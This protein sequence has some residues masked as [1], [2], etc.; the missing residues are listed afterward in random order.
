[1]RPALAA[2]KHAQALDVLGLNQFANHTDIRAAW[3]KQAFETHPDRPGGSVDAFRRVN[4]AYEI[5]S[6][7][8][9]AKAWTPP[10]ETYGAPDPQPTV[11]PDRPARPRIKTSIV[12]LSQSVAELCR[13]ELENASASN[14]AAQHVPVSM[15]RKGREVSYVVASTLRE[16][17]NRVALPT[18]ELESRKK[19]LRP[20]MLDLNARQDG[21]ATIEVPESVRTS[22]FPGAQRVRIHFGL[23]A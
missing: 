9:G 18:G 11:D 6:G 5:L 8:K 19:G 16:G 14:D 10:S 1:M 3:R 12:E 13:S 7:S 2:R 17:V 23:P 15:R 20:E 22:K 21:R 4:E